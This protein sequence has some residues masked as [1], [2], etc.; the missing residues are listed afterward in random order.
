MAPFQVTKSE[1]ATLSVVLF[2]TILGVLVHLAIES[3]EKGSGNPVIQNSAQ[4]PVE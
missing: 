1:K 3:S 2:L 4:L